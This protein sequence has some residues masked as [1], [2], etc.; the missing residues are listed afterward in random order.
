MQVNI[1]TS[2]RHLFWDVDVKKL[3]RKKHSQ[4][5]VQRVLEKGDINALRAL[6]ETYPSQVI[7]QQL[8]K[9]YNLSSSTINF[10]QIF[11]TNHGTF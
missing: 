4:Y 1:L 9:P 5:I 8:N 10:W 2:F 7:K 11:F 6:F 3:D